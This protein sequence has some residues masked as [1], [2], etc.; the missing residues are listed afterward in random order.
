M[1]SSTFSLNFLEVKHGT[2]PIGL[3]KFFS[4]RIMKKI[5][6]TKNLDEQMNN[7]SIGDKGKD[8]EQS[9]VKL[10]FGDHDVIAK[11]LLQISFATPPINV[12]IAIKLDRSNFLNRREQVISLITVYGVQNYVN[13]RKQNLQNSLKALRC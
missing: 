13:G 5:T 2:E 1:V 3:R 7:I 11:Q 9:V 10:S 12:S 6:Q 8:Y 4:S